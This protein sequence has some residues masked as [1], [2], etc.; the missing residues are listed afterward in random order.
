[1]QFG[2]IDMESHMA[3]LE[4][5][6]RKEWIALSTGAAVL[7]GIAVRKVLQYAWTSKRQ[8]GP[9]LDPSEERTPWKQA[10][11]WAGASGVSV[12]IA[13]VIGVRLA[14]GIWRKSKHAE[15]PR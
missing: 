15:P 1:M 9:P 2:V 12:G 11:L 6:E 13:R 10:L 5:L 14:S 8:E 7:A 4:N 3:V